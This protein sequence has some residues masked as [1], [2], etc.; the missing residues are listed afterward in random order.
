MK[1]T[2]LCTAL[3]A[4]LVLL[5]A[6]TAFAADDKTLAK[7][8]APSPVPV[9]RS[10]NV[11]STSNVGIIVNKGDKLSFS[12]SGTIRFGIFAG[13]GGP[14][15]I[16]YGTRYNIMN[17]FNHGALMGQIANNGWFLIGNGGTLTSPWHGFLQL[18]VNDNDTWNNGG[19]FV[20][21]VT[22]IPSKEPKSAKQRLEELEIIKSGGMSSE[23]RLQALTQW[24][25][26]N[27]NW[28]EGL[29][30]LP[31]TIADAERQNAEA[32]QQG[33]EEPWGISGLWDF[34]K[35]K[36]H[37]GGETEVRQKSD[38]NDQATPGAGAQGVYGSDGN[39]IPDEGT[40]DVA[41]P[42]GIPLVSPE[43]KAHIATDVDLFDDLV[44][45]Y[46]PLVGETMY[47]EHYNVPLPER[48]RT[49]AAQQ[50]QERWETEN[51]KKR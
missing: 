44:K 26:E 45:T 2:L 35:E 47:R 50:A 42:G 9:K 41:R 48:M 14:G 10:V 37:P 25:G 32:R 43:S 29:A 20:V 8:K 3:L 46:G 30:P 36:Y 28:A 12:A 24:L 15:G 34:Q 40:P 11:I 31:P 6:Q 16:D 13:S 27:P 51:R 21:N 22:L 18:A 33:L 49:P 38:M 23:A 5:K 39:L 4:C 7:A 19:A 1:N 17:Q